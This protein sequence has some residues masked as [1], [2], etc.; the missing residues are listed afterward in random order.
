MLRWLRGPILGVLSMALWFANTIFWMCPFFLVAICKILVPNRRWRHGCTGTLDDIASLWMFVNTSFIN[1]FIHVKWEVVGDLELKT[2]EWYLVLANHQSW[3]DI[4]VLAQ[5][6]NR[7]IPLLKFFLKKQLIYVPLLGF[8]WW[9]LDFPF[10]KRYSKATLAKRP[11]LAGRDLATTIKACERFKDLPISVMN[12]VEGT[13]HTSGKW[14]TQQSSFKHLLQ[15]KA[16]GVAYTLQAM[17]KQLHEI[18]DVT[19]VYPKGLKSLWHL[20]SGKMQHVKIYLRQ[21][22][23][24]PNL[25]GDYQKDPQFREQFQQW[26]NRLWHEKDALLI[27]ELGTVP[28]SK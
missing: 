14:D 27:K 22:H 18:I 8:A 2:N 26:L 28:L 3:A 17:G 5:V 1:F 21:I 11:E 15:P 4:V 6:L 23:I 13:R 9:A 16:G 25:I 12:F 10:M 7:K 20:M 19:I 24:T